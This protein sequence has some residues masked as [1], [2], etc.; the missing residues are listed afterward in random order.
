MQA[1]RVV[2][3][4]RTL[5]RVVIGGLVLGMLADL[6]SI[7]H[8]LSG[9]TLL[10]QY[11]SGVIGEAA[12]VAWDNTFAT[13]GL[14][15]SGAF[16]ATAIAWLVWQHRLVASVEP[17]LGEEPVKTPGRSV[18]WWFVPF[19]NL[20][21][22]P[23]IYGDLK[24]KFATGAGSI[25]GQWFGIYIL[26]NV[27][28]NLAGRYWGIV[29]D[30]DGLLTGLNLWIASDAMSIVAALVAIRLILTLQ[31]GQDA[32]IAAP[33]IA[34]NTLEQAVAPAEGP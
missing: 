33:P 25:V 19:A 9:S 8:N 7:V 26:A 17:L 14:A 13:I 6:V 12:V 5:S 34:I 20:V 24:E 1:P 16:I 18:L 22:I 31:R 21:V 15:Q 4:S 3:S 23:R 11:A 27:V 30:L 2:R 29:D 28:T 32:R 10:E